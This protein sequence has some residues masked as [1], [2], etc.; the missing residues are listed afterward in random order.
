MSEPAENLPASGPPSAGGPAGGS[1]NVGVL[2]RLILFVCLIAAIFYA[3]N[4]AMRTFEARN[5]AKLTE[6]KTVQSFGLIAPAPRSL[7]SRFSDSQGRL[8]ADPPSSPDQFID[9]DPIVVAHILGTEDNPSIDWKHFEKYLAETT[10]KK[11]ADQ[12]FDDSADELAQID[13]NKIT[14]LA[15]HAADTPFVVN[16]FGFQ[17]I[18][19]LGADSAPTAI[20][21]ISSLRPTARSPNRPN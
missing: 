9:P 19:V 13:K 7:A 14:V 21:W 5:S 1:G 18:A 6:D 20:I 3:G 8:V 10:G 16:N 15:L 11:V 17:P 2:A 4:A 12:P